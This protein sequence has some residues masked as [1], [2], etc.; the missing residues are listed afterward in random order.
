MTCQVCYDE[1]SAG[2]FSSIPTHT[3]QE[4]HR[5]ICDL[6]L[7]RHLQGMFTNIF[8]DDVR[9]PEL[10]CHQKFNYETIKYI[11]ERNN[12]KKL[13]ER[14]DQF[15]CRHRLEK[16][17][18]FIWCSNPKCSFGQLNDGG[19]ANNIVT[20]QR[21]QQKT[22]FKHKIPWHGGL[23]CKQYDAQCDKQ[24]QA[25]LKWITQYTKQCSKCRFRI[26]KND[27]CDHM[28][29]IKCGY[30]FC[31]SCLADFNSIRKDGNHRHDPSCKHYAAYHRQ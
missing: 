9:C 16:M 28:T 27:G 29:C 24:I 4:Q 7:H 15:I 8:T 5:T 23:T 26:E 10:N 19:E 12:D 20:C 2:D 3:C 14:Y 18:E 30:E 13:F 1:K 22:C 31:W 25:S 6:C 11:L 21:C 17:N